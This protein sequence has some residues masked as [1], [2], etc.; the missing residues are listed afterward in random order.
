MLRLTA[1]SAMGLAAMLA[2]TA[3]PALAADLTVTVDNAKQHAAITNNVAAKVSVLYLVGSDGRNYDV[4]TVIDKGATANVV[5]R[6]GMP[7]R[8]VEAVCEMSNPPLNFP[9]ASGGRYHLSVLVQ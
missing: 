3:L 7:D 5:L 1:K 4:T 2:L 9:K 8:V 6:R